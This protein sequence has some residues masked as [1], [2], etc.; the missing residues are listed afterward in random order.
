M[1]V[2]KTLCI[3]GISIISFEDAIKTAFEDTALSI[4]HIFKVEVIGLRLNIRENRIYEYIADTK[5]SFKIDTERKKNHEE[6][7]N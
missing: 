2:T 5:I 4:D 7:R 3:Q 6:N 1:S